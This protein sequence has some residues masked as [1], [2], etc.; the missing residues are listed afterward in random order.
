M[1]NAKWRK[2][3][4]K[5]IENRKLIKQCELFDFFGS[6]IN[7]LILSKINENLE[8]FILEDCILNDITTS[9]PSTFYK[10]IEDIEFLRFYT[11]MPPEIKGKIIKK[12]Q[13]IEEIKRYLSSFGEFYFEE[14]ENRLKVLGDGR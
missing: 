13:N 8:S 11:E 12:E 10:E 4:V 3:F 1:N 6:G 14:D 9:E 5:I 2:L 7:T